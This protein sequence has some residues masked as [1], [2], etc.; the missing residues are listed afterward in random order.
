MPF[1]SLLHHHASAQRLDGPE[2]SRGQKSA[3]SDLQNYILIAFTRLRE[4]IQG[5][6]NRGIHKHVENYGHLGSPMGLW[7]LLG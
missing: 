1:S 6:L 5:Y 2:T 7:V 3:G 4:F